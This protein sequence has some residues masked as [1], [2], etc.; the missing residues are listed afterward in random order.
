MQRQTTCSIKALGLLAN[1]E[2]FIFIF[3][4]LTNT[5]YKYRNCNNANSCSSSL[6]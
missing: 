3:F 2:N 4:G 6:P 5:I 1:T